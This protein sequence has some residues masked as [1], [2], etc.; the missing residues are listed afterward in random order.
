MDF[1]FLS[2]EKVSA[3]VAEGGSN[4]LKNVLYLVMLGDI[5]KRANKSS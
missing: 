4:K 5:L 2:A 1:V 3:C